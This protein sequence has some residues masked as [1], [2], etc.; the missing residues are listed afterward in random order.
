MNEETKENIESMSR[1]ISLG[2]KGAGI[3]AWLGCGGFS[4]FVIYVFC[5]IYHIMFLY[6][7]CLFLWFSCLV[8]IIISPLKMTKKGENIKDVEYFINK[9]KN[10]MVTKENRENK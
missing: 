2:A 3:G 10:F 6:Y 1:I 5:A 8:L 7:I 9:F 4:L